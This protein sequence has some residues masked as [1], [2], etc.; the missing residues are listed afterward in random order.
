MGGTGR[1]LAMRMRRAVGG[2]DRT[3]Q[4]CRAGKKMGMEESVLNILYAS[5]DGFARHLG[6]SMCS[7]F[8]RNK[9]ALE[10]TVYVLS[11]G[12]C[13]ENREKLQ[14]IADQ[15]RRKLVILELGDIRERFDFAVDTGGYDISIM[16]RLFLGEMLPESVDR[17]LYL[18]CDTVVVQSLAK[19]WKEDLRG[20]VLGAVM[21]P[22]IYTAVKESIGLGPED[23]YYNSGMLLVDV[24]RWREE[25]VQE[26]LLQFLKDKGG[27]LFASDQDLINGALKGRIHTL[28]PECNFFPNYRYFSYE[29]LV[30]HAP[31]YRAVPKEEFRRAK[32]QPRIIHYMGDERPWIRGNWNHYRLAYEK[33]LAMTPWAGTP[34]EPGKEKYMLLYHVM[35]YA[36]AVCPE[37]RWY[38]SRKFGMKAVMSR[39]KN[40]DAEP[41]SGHETGAC[42]NG[43]SAEQACDI[44]VLLASWNGAD[45]IEE[46]LDS[47]LNQTVPQIR[48]LVSDDGSTDGTREI[49]E[50][51]KQKYPE[52]VLLNHRSDERRRGDAEDGIPAAAGNFFW[53]LESYCAG[54]HH[55]YVM[56]SDQDDVWK[57]DKAEKLLGEMRRL[58]ARKG[59]DHPILVHSDMEVVDAGLHSIHPSFFVYQHCDPNGTTFPELLAENRVTGGA[60]MMNRALAELFPERPEACFMHDWW[61]A[62]AA[63]CF[64]TIG[65][66]REPLYLYRQHGTNTLGAKKTGGVKDVAARAAREAEVRE[67]YRRMAAQAHAFGIMYDSKLSREQKQI[68]KSYLA[69]RYQ[70]VAGRIR[71]IVYNRFRKSSLLQ[72][73]AQCV[74]IPRADAD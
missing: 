18:D 59:A 8:D 63:S 10:I 11:L 14:Q 45:Y 65:C 62:L 67:N 57:P 50:T 7:L 6:T 74:T 22:T 12:L 44:V 9:K 54:D 19:I 40:R 71:N 42:A 39:K 47:I 33:Y 28:M 51:Y 21:E 61:I 70:S 53:L 46:Q 1:A 13:A 72:T 58:E 32:K 24:K 31:S 68:L 3:A 37:V 48:I 4:P 20:A 27:A 25:R 17:V 35:D 15:Y 60:V 34:K 49:L 43:G 66:V 38:I 56:L 69:L 5:N 29:T 26:Q 55:G 64:G 52:R 23:G 30:K 2:T 16:G 73:A 36:T 41:V